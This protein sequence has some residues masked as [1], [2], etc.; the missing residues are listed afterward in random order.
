MAESH[1]TRLRYLAG[2]SKDGLVGIIS[3]LPFKVELKDISKDGSQWVAWF[4]LPDM[5]DNKAF[6]VI[7]EQIEKM[8]KAELRSATLED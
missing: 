3:A 4:V 8:P 2:P 1:S 6:Q 7:K 5:I